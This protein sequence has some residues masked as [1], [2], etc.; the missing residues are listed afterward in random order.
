MNRIR[1]CA[2]YGVVLL[3]V[4]LWGLCEA[5]TVP[6]MFNYQGQLRRAN[7]QPVEAGIYTVSFRIYDAA[8]GGHLI[9]GRSQVVQADA[10]GYFNALIGEGGSELTS[11]K[12]EKSNLADVFTGDTAG[13]RYL[14]IQVAGAKPFSVRQRLLSMPQAFTAANA[15]GSA[16]DFS[17]GETMTVSSNTTV[18]GTM[19]V[20]QYA[21]FD[22]PL[23][24]AGDTVISNSLLVDASVD[25]QGESDFKQ[26]VTMGHNLQQAGSASFAK[27]VSVGG[28]LTLM[29]PLA[30]FGSMVAK[31]TSW[32]G[33]Y[34]TTPTN[35]GFYVANFFL[36]QTNNDMDKHDST[37]TTQGKVFH[38]KTCFKVVLADPQLKYYQVFMLPARAGQQVVFNINSKHTLNLFWRP[39]YR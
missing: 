20:D 17:V 29:Q 16:G 3:L 30:W 26:A 38:F 2:G 12:P 28:T 39:M 25:F 1:R 13:V 24:V 9:W 21:E 32:N 23:Q 22:G 5:A 33:T 27:P 35:D 31:K 18:A 15:S 37:I 10:E 11:E 7:G 36:D 14:E 6:L 34:T 4:A 8:A 19:T